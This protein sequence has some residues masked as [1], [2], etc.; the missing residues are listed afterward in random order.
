MFKVIHSKSISGDIKDNIKIN[1]NQLFI[2][3]VKILDQPAK[4]SSAFTD[5]KNR[6]L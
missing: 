4:S 5:F 3:P 1:L 6:S 2:K